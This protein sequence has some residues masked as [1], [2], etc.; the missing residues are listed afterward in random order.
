MGTLWLLSSPTRFSPLAA[1]FRQCGCHWPQVLA[2]VLGPVCTPAIFDPKQNLGLSLRGKFGWSRYLP[3]GTAQTKHKIWMNPNT[4]V[5]CSIM[6]LISSSSVISFW[7]AAFLNQRLICPIYIWK[8]MLIHVEEQTFMLDEK[9][10]TV[11][12]K[13]YRKSENCNAHCDQR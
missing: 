2:Q 3:I 9:P 11:V 5:L 6:S 13:S 7:S 10:L 1:D 4:I 8:K 12:R